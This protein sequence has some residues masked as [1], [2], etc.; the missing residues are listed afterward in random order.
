LQGVIERKMLS[1]CT[2]RRNFLGREYGALKRKHEQEQHS[3]IHLVKISK[4]DGW[5]LKM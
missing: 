4:R 1:P 3:K 2:N 5:E